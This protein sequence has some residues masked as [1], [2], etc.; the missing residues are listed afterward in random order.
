MF[1]SYRTT[2]YLAQPPQGHMCDKC[3]QHF[4]YWRTRCRYKRCATHKYLRDLY[5]ILNIIFS[6][7]LLRHINSVVFTLFS[8][9]SQFSTEKMYL[10]HQRKRVSSAGVKFSFF[11]HIL[12]GTRS[13]PSNTLFIT[14]VRI[15][16]KRKD[17]AKK[18]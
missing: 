17:F 11:I 3:K 10:F 6:K 4:G 8:S 1:S 15:Q 14:V 13:L 18:N 2:R 16:D 12:D 5:K 9:G 7:N